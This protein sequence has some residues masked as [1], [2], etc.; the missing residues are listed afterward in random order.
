MRAQ[1]ALTL[2]CGGLLTTLG[3]CEGGPTFIRGDWNGTLTY[4]DDST[5]QMEWAIF[6]RPPFSTGTEHLRVVLVVFDDACAETIDYGTLLPEADGTITFPILDPGA[7]PCFPELATLDLL[8]GG[9]LEL[10]TTGTFNGDTETA[11]G[12]F[13]IR[14]VVD[15]EEVSKLRDGAWTATR[16]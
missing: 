13:V 6:D 14:Q 16:E 5:Q 4:A 1:L 8:E 3:G 12:T 15:G 7:N 10:V 2:L 11:Q 9:S